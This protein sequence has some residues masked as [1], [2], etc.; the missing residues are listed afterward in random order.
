MTLNKAYLE[1]E[2]L[3]TEQFNKVQ[4]ADDCLEA[5]REYI[6]DFK[7]YDTLVLYKGNMYFSDVTYPYRL[8]KITFRS[9]YKHIKEL[10]IL[11]AEKEIVEVN[12]GITESLL[13]KAISA[14]SK[15]CLNNG[16]V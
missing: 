2:E 13:L 9:G 8:E 3:T 5:I 15:G 11:Q 14:A 7:R 1:L 16:D 4:D 12:V 10:P 6:K